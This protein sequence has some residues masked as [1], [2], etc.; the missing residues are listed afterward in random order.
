MQ[1]RRDG[2]L[3]STLF[4][5]SLYSAN[6]RHNWETQGKKQTGKLRRLTILE[7]MKRKV[8]KQALIKKAR[9]PDGFIGL[10]F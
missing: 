4:S 8:N 2:I 6:G 7:G 5:Q 3:K 9:G 10:N 1:D